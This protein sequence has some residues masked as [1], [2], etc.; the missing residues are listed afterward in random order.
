MVQTADLMNMNSI[1]TVVTMEKVRMALSACTF[2]EQKITH[3]KNQ[4]KQ[5]LWTN[6]M[7]NSYLD[8]QLNPS[9]GL[10]MNTNQLRRR[11]QINI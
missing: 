2:P 3:Q 6:F 4:N 7:N 8:E 5:N 1:Q 10:T 11:I 9:P